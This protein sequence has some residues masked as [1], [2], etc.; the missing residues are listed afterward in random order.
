MKHGGRIPDTVREQLRPGAPSPGDDRDGPGGDGG[1]PEEAGGWSRRDFVKLSAAAGGGLL[2]AF[3]LPGCDPADEGPGEGADAGDGAAF[4]P[5]VFVRIAPDGTATVTVAKS[6]MGQGV[7]TTLALLVAEEMDLDWDRVEVEQAPAD[8]DAYGFQGTGGSASV[9]SSWDRLRKAGAG[10]RAALVAA[11]AAEL[12]VPEDEL[13]TRAGEV[14]HA[15]SGR[16]ADYGDIASAAAEQPVPEEPP[17]KSPD[18]WT[19][20]GEEHVGVEVDDVVTG[21]ATY[22]SDIQEDGLLHAAVARTPAHG[23][24]VA[25]WDAGDALDVPGVVDVVEVPAQGGGVNVHAGVAVLA[26]DTW[27]AFRGRDALEVEWDPGPYGGDSSDDHSRTMRE[28]VETPGSVTLNRVGDPDSVLEGADEVVS[29]TWE[30]PFLAHAT[31]EPQ[32]CVAEFDGETCRLRSPAQFPNWAAGAVAGALGIDR[33]DVHLEIPRLGGGYGRRINPDFSVEAAL[34]AREAD[35]PVKVVWSRE[36]DM[37]HDFYRPC[38]V[39]RIEAALGDDGYPEAWRHRF[40]DPA[41]DGTIEDEVDEEA[42]GL[43]ESTGAADMLYRV[44]HRTSEYTYLDAGLTRGWWRAVS[45]THTVFAVETFVDELAE[46]AGIDPV[47]YRLALIDDLQVDRPEPNEDFPP[48]P[49][50][51]KGVLRLAAEE[52]GWGEP[53]PEGR[54]RG[55]ACAIDHFSYAAEVVEI[56]LDGGDLTIEKVVCAADC[57]PVLNPDGARAQAE[58]AIVQGLSAALREE[59]TVSDGAVEQGN[60][61][62]YPILR[63]DEAPREIEVHFAGTDAHPTGMGEPGLP[64]AAPALANALYR[65]TGT[66][67]RTLPLSV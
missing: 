33:G 67:Q 9:R 11:A 48:D 39:H 32:T 21:R 12:E 13:E 34:I 46:R 57:G 51:L 15:S 7:R 54:H 1:P 8:E 2:V 16:S 18:E 35:G 42:F 31:M 53:L 14:V 17:L 36:E 44:P 43:A 45:T 62:D 23:G 4:E 25:D 28:A 64:P 19:L 50:R 49:E 22:G 24:S 55:I 37:R 59:I 60:F 56:S 65:A 20:L 52:A 47:E 3:H 30:V 29:G 40:C 41:I 10:A 61:D 38:A 58:G 63:I 5:N 27:S 6:E 26:E 66:R